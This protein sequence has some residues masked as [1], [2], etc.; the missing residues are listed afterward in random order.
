MLVLDADLGGSTL[1]SEARLVQISDL[2]GAP[3]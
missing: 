2:K 1:Q 3:A